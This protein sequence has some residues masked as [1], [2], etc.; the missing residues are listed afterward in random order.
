MRKKREKSPEEVKHMLERFV[1]AVAK[2]EIA[3]NTT[4]VK[5]KALFVE[6]LVRESPSS[7]S[8]RLGQSLCYLTFLQ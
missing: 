4:Y 5:R 7:L 6:S 3:D 2:A 1:F 8:L